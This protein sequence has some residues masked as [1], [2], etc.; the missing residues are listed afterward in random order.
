MEKEEAFAKCEE[1]GLAGTHAAIESG[2]WGGKLVRFAREWI[3]I[4]EGR[5]EEEGR[6]K[7]EDQHEAQLTALYDSAIG[8][9]R[10]INDSADG[11]QEKITE[12]GETIESL[13]ER[14]E[15]LNST[16][17]NASKSSGKV[18]WAL[19]GLTLVISVVAVIGLLK[20]LNIFPI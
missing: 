13:D 5:V 16:I 7:Q 3:K 8:I 15:D 17:E 14:L 1:L 20:E 19:W 4:E 18:A 10:Q 11:V 6:F 9:V 12:L 2:D